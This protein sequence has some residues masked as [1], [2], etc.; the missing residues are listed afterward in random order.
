LRAHLAIRIYPRFLIVISPFG[1]FAARGSAAIF[2]ATKPTLLGSLKASVIIIVVNHE[3]ASLG[4]FTNFLRMSTV[5][6]CVVV[7]APG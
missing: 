2:H 5:T 3:G 4:T 6:L 7:A 1:D